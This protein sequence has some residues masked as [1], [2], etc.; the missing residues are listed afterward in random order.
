MS[1]LPADIHKR[2]E[3]ER[4]RCPYCGIVAPEEEVC[5]RV[6]VDTCERALS[7]HHTMTRCVVSLFKEPDDAEAPPRQ[8]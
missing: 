5:D 7:M 1:M 2:L 8:A 4:V 6:P 3:V